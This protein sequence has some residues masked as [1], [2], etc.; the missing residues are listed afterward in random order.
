M[1]AETLQ[2]ELEQA[3]E[4]IEQVETELKTLKEEM[5]GKVNLDSGEVTAIHVKQFQAENARLREALLK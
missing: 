5:S 4:R 2:L 1:Q 3:S